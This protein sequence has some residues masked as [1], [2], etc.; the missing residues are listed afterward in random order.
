MNN[1]DNP[2]I[3]PF[4]SVAFHD[5]KEKKDRLLDLLQSHTEAGDSYV[6][7]LIRDP[8][9]M[10]NMY[11]FSWCSA[12]TLTASFCWLNVHEDRWLST[13]MLP[14]I[15][16]IPVGANTLEIYWPLALWLLQ[17]QEFGM[18]KHPEYMG[19]TLDYQRAVRYLQADRGLEARIMDV[20][21]LSQLQYERLSWS[22][23]KDTG[24]YFRK[25]ISSLVCCDFKSFI[26]A[27]DYLVHGKNMY[28]VDWLMERGN[29]I[30]AKTIEIIEDMDAN[31][32]YPKSLPTKP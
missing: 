8:E 25:A 28:R 7:D 6:L 30:R 4:R 17:S 18:T 11:G 29:S 22:N 14:I 20:V 27:A 10:R 21:Y 15:Q 23:E 13:Q 2:T 16:A 31:K 12:K 3:S 1:N 24:Y 5:D 19:A 32:W 9:M 26:E